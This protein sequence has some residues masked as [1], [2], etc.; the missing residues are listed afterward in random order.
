MNEPNP[1]MSVDELNA[2]LLAVFPQANVGGPDFR[3][4]SVE[5]GRVAIRMKTDS[6]HLRP[7]GTVSGPTIFTLCDVAGYACALS[8]I[9]PEALAV[10]TNLNL[11][12]MRKADPGTLECSARILKLGKRLMVFDAEVTS[13]G[14]MIAH[15]T[16][17]YAL[18]PKV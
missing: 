17:T 5:P 4:L 1:V 6:S 13:E 9:G 16:G 12:F 10:T 11:N 3:V 8:H 15:A 2:F 14:S 18:P 7:G